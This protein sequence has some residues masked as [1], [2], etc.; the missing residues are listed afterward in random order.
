[1]SNVPPLTLHMLS[2]KWKEDLNRD[3]PL[4][5]QGKIATSYAEL[6]KNMWSGRHSYT[7]PRAFKVKYISIIE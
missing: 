6:I 5:M 7:V 2:D 4:G 3:N 1:M